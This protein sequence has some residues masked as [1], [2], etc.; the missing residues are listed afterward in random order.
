MG[1]SAVG[2]A[3]TAGAFFG[4]R[5]GPLIL[6]LFQSLESAWRCDT[7]DFLVRHS[8]ET[9]D[10]LGCDRRFRIRFSRLSCTWLRVPSYAVLVLR[11]WACEYVDS[12]VG[13]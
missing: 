6:V 4:N 8:H 7:G 9:D 11:L 5:L 13:V 12:R 3:G 2:G 1:N 10:E